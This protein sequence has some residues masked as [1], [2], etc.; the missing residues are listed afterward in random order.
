V[1]QEAS[2]GTA[3][4]VVDLL[5][6]TSE[7]EAARLVETYCGNEPTI[8]K[9]DFFHSLL[10]A[11]TLDEVRAQLQA[12]ALSSLRVLAV[13]DRHLAVHGVFP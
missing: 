3:I 4:F 9:H 13:S 8:L 11:F 1:Y 6:P 5:R 7:A 10:A 12:G 2:P